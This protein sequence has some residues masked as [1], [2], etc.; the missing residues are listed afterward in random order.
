MTPIADLSKVPD[1]SVL[2]NKS[3][4][5]TGGASGLGALTATSFAENGYRLDFIFHLTK[6]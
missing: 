2:R 4:I 6:S 3:V 1:L 5:V